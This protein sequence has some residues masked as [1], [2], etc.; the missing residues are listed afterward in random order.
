MPSRSVADR[1]AD[2]LDNIE[3]VRR[4]IAQHNAS[5]L[6]EDELVYFAV[7]RALEII[8]EASRHLPPEFQDR[9]PELPWRAIRDAGNV[10]RHIYDMVSPARVWET[11][12]QQLTG[13]ELMARQE[14]LRLQQ[15]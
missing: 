14:L 12:T 10:Y 8:S 11:A 5:S 9:H 3:R 1:L 15:P 13:L 2:I 4:F 6:A 7:V